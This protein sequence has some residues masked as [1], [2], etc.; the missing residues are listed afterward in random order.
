MSFPTSSSSSFPSSPSSFSF[1]D[2]SSHA[3]VPYGWDD[4]WE[5]EFRPYA[6]QGLIPGRVVRVDR[7]M[8]DVFTPDGAVRADTALVMPP[9][10]MRIVCTGDW[11]AVDRP[12]ADPR[13]V[14][15]LLP[16]RSAFVR[17]T[18]SKRSEGQVL[19][20]NVDHA[21]VCV[22]LAAELDLG[23]LERF[24][25]LAWESGERPC[26]ARSFRPS[27]T[28]RNAFWT[29]PGS[30]RPPSPSPCTATW[31]E[32]FPSAVCGASTCAA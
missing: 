22:S 32:S 23:R 25:S 31:R 28:P 26:S 17:S 10:P 20:A 8:C 3:L 12:G 6:E 5:A 14:R 29:R 16:R 19:A 15:D 30:R 21:V 11:A 7:N 4:V 24:L 18:S 27:S 13:F 1:L 9:D 2:D